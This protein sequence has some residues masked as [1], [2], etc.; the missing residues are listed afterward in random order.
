MSET[1][2]VIM[3]EDKS[4]PTLVATVMDAHAPMGGDRW[5]LR[6]QPS[7]D[8]WSNEYWTI[9]LNAGSRNIYVAR[10]FF[11]RQEAMDYM[12][13]LANGDRD[14]IKITLTKRQTQ[15]LMEMLSAEIEDRENHEIDTSDLEDILNI[16][17][18]G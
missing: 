5:E 16:F 12:N 13:H 15:I 14:Q 7:R 11:N 1:N 9:R 10:S 4:D 17:G 3:N 8:A 2:K 6:H 18:E